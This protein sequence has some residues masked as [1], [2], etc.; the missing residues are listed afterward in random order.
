MTTLVHGSDPEAVYDCF[1][2]SNHMG[3]V[4]GGHYTAYCQHEQTL[5]PDGHEHLGWHS[6]N[7]RSVMPTTAGSVVTPSAYVL[8]YRRRSCSK[9][10]P[11]DV[12]EICR[13]AY[14]LLVTLCVV[15]RHMCRLRPGSKA[16]TLL[17]QQMS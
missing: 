17:D 2:I 12:L 8:F 3:S 14:L 11:P 15:A 7:D 10:D 5:L 6:Y 1:A 4:S 16:F 9:Q 13:C